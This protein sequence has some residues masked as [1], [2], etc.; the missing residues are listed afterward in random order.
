MS[1]EDW[2]E[3]GSDLA[4]SGSNNLFG[5]RP[6]TSAFYG[7]DGPAHTDFTSVTI[8][9]ETTHDALQKVIIPPPLEIDRDVPAVGRI[10]AFTTPNYRGRDGRLAPYAG[11][12]IQAPSRWKEHR[13]NTSIEFVDGVAPAHDKTVRDSPPL[14]GAIYGM[15]KK[16]ADIHFYVNGVES[17][18]MSTVQEGDDIIVM[19]ARRGRRL[20]EMRLRVSKERTGSTDMLST[21][22]EEGH[23]EAPRIVLGVRE[24]PT[25]DYSGYVDRSITTRS[26][27]DSAAVTVR[28]SLTAEPVSLEFWESELEALDQLKIVRLIGA[29]VAVSDISKENISGMSILEHLPLDL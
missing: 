14:T 25:V 15:L 26:I 21:E 16:F 1:R 29:S 17:G 8:A 2:A 5:A 4:P 20:A 28:T 9:F 11:V 23:R 22:S 13:G 3:F 27:T 10:M 18:D 6:G 12:L 7:Y 24:I 19:L